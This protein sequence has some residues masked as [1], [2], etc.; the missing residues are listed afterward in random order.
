MLLEN[1]LLMIVISVVVS[2]LFVLLVMFSLRKR[3]AKISKEKDD[4]VAMIVHDLRSP[5]AVIK[6][7]ADLLMHEDKNLTKED[8]DKLLKQIVDTA[9]ASLSMI[10]DVL[11]VSKMEAG[12]FEINKA[13]SD[14][15]MLLKM[16]TDR[17]L[18]VAN[19]SNIK[20]V[21]NFDATLPKVNL[22]PEKIER[23]VN[24]LLSNAIKFTPE[25]G[26]ITVSSI[27]DGNFVKVSVADTGIGIDD[28]LKNK[29]FNKFVQAGKTLKSGK[30]SS[31]GLGLK[32]SKEIVELHDGKIWIEDNKPNGSVFVFTIPLELPNF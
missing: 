15:N 4:Y 25:S 29:L 32:V 10:S 9:E 19:Q 7:S 8:M 27:I 26:Q 18:V 14:L 30:T 12:R 21:T 13:S 20:L 24:N 6:G 22:D 1:T 28:S 23:V 11:D 5:L 31:T 3:D 2:S 16:I 17:F